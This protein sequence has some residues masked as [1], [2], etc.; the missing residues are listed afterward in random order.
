MSHVG[1]NE[2]AVTDNFKL[3]GVLVNNKLTFKQHVTNT[4][5]NVNRKVFNFK[6]FVYLSFLVRLQ[7][8][9]TCI[10]H[11]ENE[12]ELRYFLSEKKCI[13]ASPK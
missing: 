12:H 1:S 3:L 2:V 11:S 10:L 9:K 8:V 6:R 13:H 5:I 4:C 7:F